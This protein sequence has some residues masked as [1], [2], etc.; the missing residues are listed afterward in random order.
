MGIFLTGDIHG[1][2]GLARLSRRMLDYPAFS[3]GDDYL[4]VLGDFGVIW[5][6]ADSGEWDLRYE[7][8]ALDWLSRRPWTTLFIDGNHENFD[9]L[10]SMDVSTWN[11]GKVHVINDKVIHL[12]RGQVYDIDGHSFFTMGGAP[13]IDKHLRIE[14]VSWWSREVPNDEERQEAI[15]NLDRMGWEVDYVLTHDCPACAYERLGELLGHYYDSSEWNIWL[16]EIEKRLSY[17]KWFYGH[18]H[19]DFPGED[20]FVPLF[21]EVLNLGSG[22]V[23]DRYADA[24]EDFDLMPEPINPYGYTIREIAEYAGVEIDDVW[25]AFD[26]EMRYSTVGLSDDGEVL[27]GKGDTFYRIMPLL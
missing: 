16:D 1:Y 12:M 20:K 22:V 7:K 2:R 13:S 8:Y 19:E 23:V 6:A 24:G 26:V 4:I 3:E 10:D 11:G 27:V 9:R 15:S 25:R 18:H 21:N 17:R 14:N 5:K